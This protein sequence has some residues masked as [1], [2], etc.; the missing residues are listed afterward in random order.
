MERAL[1][2]FF[3]VTAALFAKPCIT[4]IYFGNGVWNTEE[5]AIENKI[6]LTKLLLYKAE[7]PLDLQKEGT[8]FVFKLAYNPSRGVREDLVET[9]WQL[10]ESGQI[11]DGYFMAVYAAL[12]T[13]SGAEEFIAKLKKIIAE[14][15]ADV[16]SMFALYKRSSFDQKRNVLLVAHSQGNLFGNRM[17]TLMSD[18][19]KRKFRMVSVGTP[20]DHVAGDGPYVTL[21][22]DFVI[23][24]IPGS[25]PANADGFGHTFVGAYLDE[26]SESPIWIAR[27]VK[28][29]Y[30]DLKRVSNCTLYEYVYLSIYYYYDLDRIRVVGKV[31]GANE[32]EQIAEFDMVSIP[33]EPVNGSYRCPDNYIWIGTHPDLSEPQAGYVNWNISPFYT[34][35]DVNASKDKAI[36][37][38]YEQR[39]ASTTFSGELYDSVYTLF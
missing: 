7:N 35:E 6:A 22:G 10:R 17:Y 37:Y 32:N 34:K 28:E 30:E 12:A 11:T 4:D 29:A 1:L 24:P 20:A 13:E 26:N 31:A 38:S 36:Y 3:I 33:A 2:I 8:E 15:N 25:L 23:R 5:Q 39:C 21:T 18:R 9:F 19:Q 16:D 14:Y 27:Y